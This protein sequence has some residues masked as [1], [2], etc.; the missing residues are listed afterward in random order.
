MSTTTGEGQGQGT[1][2]K[3]ALTRLASDSDYRGRAIADPALIVQDYQL[4][5][6]EIQALRQAAEMSGVDTSEIDRVVASEGQGLAS[7]VNVTVSCCCCCCCGETGVTV[8]LA[9]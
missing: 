8:A 5:E 2:F 9:S 7:N 6:R 4:S 3:E 1:A